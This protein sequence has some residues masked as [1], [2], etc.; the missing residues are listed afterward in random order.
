M[1]GSDK[2]NA[3]YID[4]GTT[5]A[6]FPENLMKIIKTHFV[7]FCNALPNNC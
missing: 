7:W 4:S 5:F 2:F 1:A 3:A 6:Y